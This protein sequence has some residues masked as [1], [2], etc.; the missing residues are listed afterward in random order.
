MRR[1]FY[2][3]L[4]FVGIPL[5]TAVLLA[6]TV[7]GKVLDR[8]NAETPETP[9]RVV[10]EDFQTIW[11]RTEEYID[12]EL[13]LKYLIVIA[14]RDTDTSSPA[15]AISLPA[16]IPRPVLKSVSRVEPD[17]KPKPGRR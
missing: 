14:G 12:K 9:K 3:M 7:G 8:W 11:W 4:L 1:N 15:V 13:G 2:A 5:L 10:G 6:V 17:K 16:R